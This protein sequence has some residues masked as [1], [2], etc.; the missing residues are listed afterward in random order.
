MPSWMFS[1]AA[2]LLSVGVLA[3]VLT[4]PVNAAEPVNVK[5]GKALLAPD[6][7]RLQFVC[8]HL[9]DK[10]DPRTGTFAKFT[11]AVEADAST[12]TLKSLSLEIDANSLTTE[13]AKLTAHLKSPDFF[14][15]REHP[16]AGFV[17]KK[18]M[19]GAAA[20]EFKVTGDLTLHGVTKEISVPVKAAFTGSGLTVT[21][22]FAIDR[23]EFGMKYG[24]DKVEKNVTITFVI[25]EKNKVFS[26]AGK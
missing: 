24:L 25:G 4:A 19:P 2:A 10:P 11:G 12:K 22:E 26:E 1:Q 3:A 23:S 14:D 9:G 13:I 15:T 21:S 18:F 5:D 8:A 20:G 17:G 7:T 6:N 16:K